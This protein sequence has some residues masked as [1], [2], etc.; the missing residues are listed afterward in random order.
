MFK[1][2]QDLFN[3]GLL[4]MQPVLVGGFEEQNGAFLDGKVASVF[5]TTSFIPTAESLLD[6]DWSFEF[7]PAGKGGHAVAIG[8]GN[9][10]ICSG[11][12]EQEK[13]AAVKFLEY[14]SS[15]EIVSEFFMGT[16]NLPTR[17]S[18]MEDA[19]VQAFLGSNPAYKTMV[20][21]LQYGKAAPSTTKNIR[22][23]F[24]R[25]NDMIARITLNNEDPKTV[26]DEYDALFQSE[27]DEAKSF[28]EFIY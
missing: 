19:E 9:F 24:N 11:L 28:G 12:S 22:D 3:E 14:M 15:P 25:V 17:K 26:L 23:V 5:Q 1:Y 16:G 6:Y 7:I 10:A 13:G 18:V 21:Q 20:D 8:G 2:F 27:F 4:L